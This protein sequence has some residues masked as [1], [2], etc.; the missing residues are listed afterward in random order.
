MFATVNCYYRKLAAIKA[1]LLTVKTI[2]IQSSRQ[3]SVERLSNAADI[4]K[5]GRT[6]KIHLR[7]RMILL[8]SGGGD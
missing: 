2:P 3:P 5:I 8:N 4:K 1:D 6:R 7:G